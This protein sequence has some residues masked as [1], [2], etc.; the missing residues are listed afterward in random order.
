[1][2][3]AARHV[4]VLGQGKLNNCPLSSALGSKERDGLAV[5][6]PLGLLVGHA[7]LKIWDFSR[8]D[9][10]LI[11][12]C[13]KHGYRQAHRFVGL[14][15][16]SPKYLEHPDPAV[17]RQVKERRFDCVWRS[18]LDPVAVA[19]LPQTK[20]LTEVHYGALRNVIG[21]NKPNCTLGHEPPRV[22]GRLQ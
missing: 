2:R 16:C 11:P 21:F 20:G 19:A 13:R 9:D 15:E 6:D 5:A 10:E 4:P 3:R 14:I 8:R 12:I 1:M 7:L 17:L 18:Y 22:K